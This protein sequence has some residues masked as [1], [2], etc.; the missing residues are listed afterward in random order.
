MM[1]AEGTIE[2]AA[3]AAKWSLRAPPRPPVDRV[4]AALTQPDGLIAGGATPT[5]SSPR[6]ATST[7]AGSTA[8]TRAGPP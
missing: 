5:S 6:A 8:T 2:Q 3:T 4:W 1:N 7:C